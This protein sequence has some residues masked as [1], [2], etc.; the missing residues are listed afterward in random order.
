MKKYIAILIGI[1]VLS[2]MVFGGYKFIKR[3][4]AIPTQSEA[5]VRM[6]TVIGEVSREYKGQNIL[7]YS[8]SVPEVA[9]TSVEM[10]GALIKVEN[11]SNPYSTIYVSYE[12]AR[13]YGP[14]DYIDSIVAPHVSVINVTDV[15]KIGGYDWQTAETEGSE[16]HIASP[17]NGKWL[18]VVENK[19]TNHAD[20]EKTLES[21]SA[22]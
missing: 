18:V 5:S 19:K 15:V 9:T 2:G 14:V 1:V 21:F 4:K 13:G 17:D 16:W 12:G 3:N 10:D 11:G 20:V 8:F 6:R 22:N 7:G